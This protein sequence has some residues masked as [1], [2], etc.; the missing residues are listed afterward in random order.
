MTPVNVF[1]KIPKEKISIG[2][3]AIFDI[4]LIAFILSLSMSKFV[5]APGLSVDLN[6]E[7][8]LPT[9]SS[10]DYVNVDNDITVLTA[11][12]N[13]MII[14]QGA[15]YDKESLARQMEKSKFNG[16]LLIKAD[17]SLTIH[18][19]LEI[20]ESAKLGGF[21]KIHIATKPKN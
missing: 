21:K 2:T 14:F 18:E 10:P 16:T 3:I 15:I 6:S 8:V 20:S 4:L 12:G 5:L 17:K 19:L 7:S 13:S 1:S 9:L 11:K